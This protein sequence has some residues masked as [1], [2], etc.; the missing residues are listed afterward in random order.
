MHSFINSHLIYFSPSFHFLYS[1][2]FFRAFDLR[3]GRL[4]N[5]FHVHVIAI[6]ISI[7]ISC[8]HLLPLSKALHVCT[9]V[10]STVDLLIVPPWLTGQFC[11]PS[12]CTFVTTVCRFLL[13]FLI[14]CYLICIAVQSQASLAVFSLQF[15]PRRSVLFIRQRTPCSWCSAPLRSFSSLLFSFLSFSS[16]SRCATLPSAQL[17]ATLTLCPCFA[18]SR[19]LS[20]PFIFFSAVVHCLKNSQMLNLFA[21]V[22][23]I[24]LFHSV[25]LSRF[26]LT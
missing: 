6:F 13:S 11:D 17:N 15:I 16:L 1:F 5:F 2:V 23:C 8:M 22:I 7:S 25:G 3:F 4:D 9:R 18:C 14:S 19:L 12:S 20:V 24:S 10:R 26:F 21:Y